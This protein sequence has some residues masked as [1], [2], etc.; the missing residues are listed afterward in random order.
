MEPSQSHRLLRDRNLRIIFLITLMAVMG[1]ASITPAFPQI[2]RELE[3]PK[4]SIGLLIIFFT[5]PGV[6]LTPILGVLADRVG[7]KKVLAPSLLLFGIAGGACAL[8]RQFEW[9]LL[10]RLVQGV[11]AAA[12]GSIN[13]TL[14]GDLYQGR[15]RAAAMGYNAAVLSMATA[16]YPFLGGL[17]STFAWY[18]PFALPLLALPIAFLVLFKLDNPEPSTTQHLKAYLQNA[19]YSLKNH[20]A[21]IYFTTSLMVFIILY[22]AYLTYVP[23]LL[24]DRFSATPLQIGLIFSCMSIVT[25]VVSSMIG[26]LN[27][28]WHGHQLVRIS[29]LF[30]STALIFI[31]L[32][33]KLPLVIVPIVCFGLGHG[34]NIPSLQ[35]LLANL[36]PIE[37][38]AAFLSMNGW[39]LRLGQ[40]LGPLI[41]GAAFIVGGVNAP[42]Y[43][44]AGLSAIMFFVLF[45][46][47][48]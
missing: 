21:L 29:F 33:P 5:F 25:A 46:M 48:R 36:A 14:I 28:R 39:V 41:A 7:R 32:M 4:S 18:Y 20:A 26:R 2:A 1:V 43:I 6:V 10:L 30:Y 24:A 8:V 44:G 12:L 9:L 3:I 16:S 38:R 19:F 35:T 17:L 31:P 34:L 27:R 23:M 13:V 37:Y 15:T 22:G 47:R 42:F 45:M 11:G 40:T